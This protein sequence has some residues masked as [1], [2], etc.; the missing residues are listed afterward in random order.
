LTIGPAAALA[1]ED[2]EEQKSD[3]GHT[4]FYIGVGATL[5]ALLDSKKTFEDELGAPTA[6][7]MDVGDS[8]GVN[9][10]GGYRFHPHIATELEV[11]WHSPFTVDYAVGEVGIGKAEWEPLVF[12]ANLKGF[13]FKSRFQPYG[14]VGIG[15]MTGELDIDEDAGLGLSRSDRMTGFAARFG[16]GG[17]LYITKHILLNAEIRYVLPTCDVNGFDMLSFGWGI[18]YRF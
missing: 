7:E 1:Q 13:L 10:R 14:V 18:Q 8:F 16:G 4:G 15:V 3:F 17:D 5:T 6:V 12:T 2:D 9:G 11:E